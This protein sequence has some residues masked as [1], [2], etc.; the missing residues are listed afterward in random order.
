MIYMQAIRFLTD[1]FNND[2]YYG[3]KYENH[4]FARAGRQ[5]ILLQRLMEKE[6]KL[7]GF[8]LNIGIQRYKTKYEQDTNHHNDIKAMLFALPTCCGLFL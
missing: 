8:N 6:E 4:N 3:A 7:T 2:V 1:H 5:G